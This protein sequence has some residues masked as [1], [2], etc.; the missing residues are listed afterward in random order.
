M[1]KLAVKVQLAQLKLME[2]VKDRIKKMKGEVN[3]VE[4]LVIIA[5]FLVITYPLYSKMISTFMGTVSDW[6]SKETDKVFTL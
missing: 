4:M 6:F 2:E 5:V 1:K 3:T